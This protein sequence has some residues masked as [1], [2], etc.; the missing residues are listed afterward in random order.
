MIT[1][2][3]TTSNHRVAMRL[4]LITLLWSLG[5]YTSIGTFAWANTQPATAMT[6]DSSHPSADGNENDMVL[7]PSGE[8]TMGDNDGLR[9]ERPKHVV[10]LNKYYMDLY[11]VSMSQYQ[12]FLDNHYDIEPPPLW[13]DG[14][15]LDEAADRP[16]V[17]V[18]WHDANAYCQSVGK[19]LPTEAEWEKAARG[20]DGRRYPWGHMQPFVD[21]ANYNQGTTGWV[22][23][24]LTLQ[25]VK[26]GIK[27]MSIRHGLKS[28]GRSP[29]G[30][31]NMAGN[32]A[33]W[34]NDWYDRHYYRESPEK[35]PSGPET[36]EKKVLRGGSWEDEPVRLRVTA[37]SAADP[38]FHDLT[39]GFRCA[40]DAKK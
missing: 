15:A 9:N 12:K 10:T 28:G 25:P 32:A 5:I 6:Q 38:D 29:Y 37:R 40:K 35:N 30:L 1:P 21:I 20:T 8:F 27:G 19:R 26:S 4:T 22:S 2:A 14:A 33:E 17:G 16:A 23:Y 3:S 7:I 36:G 11:E 18:S 39:T 34:V 13:D 24:T 31:Y